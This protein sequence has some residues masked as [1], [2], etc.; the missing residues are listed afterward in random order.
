MHVCFIDREAGMPSR[1][2]QPRDACM[3]DLASWLEKAPS[4][5][6]PESSVVE[7]FISEL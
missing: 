3:P 6:S 1:L 7:A 2:G 4:I 5:S